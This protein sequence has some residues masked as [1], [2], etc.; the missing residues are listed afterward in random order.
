MRLVLDT[1]VMV[2]ALRS[3]TGASRR[4][5]LAALER[6]RELTVL[7]SVPL[8]IEYEAVLTRPEHLKAAGVSGTDVEGLLDAFAAVAEPVTLAYL[9][10]PTL[11]DMDDD[12]V[13]EA[14]VNGQADSIVTF[15]RRDFG[16]PA[17]QFGVLVL[18]PGDAVRRLERRS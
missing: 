17:E 15:N 8:L 1:D 5:L 18:S 9:W 2:A 13:L 11:P 3:A 4:L 6:R 7:V 14:A 16:A 10:R 12:M